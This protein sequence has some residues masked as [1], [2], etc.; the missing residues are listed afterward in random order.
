MIHVRFHVFSWHGRW[1]KA[2]SIVRG[3]SKLLMNE[4]DVIWPLAVR[5][6]R[7]L[8]YFLGF[9]AVQSLVLTPGARITRAYCSP[10]SSRIGALPPASGCAPLIHRRSK[11]ERNK[12]RWQSARHYLMNH[13]GN[14]RA[15]CS[16]RF[17][18]PRI[19]QSGWEAANAIPSAGTEQEGR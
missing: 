11:S 3:Q 19:R 1:Q 15:G 4:F 13:L 2:E 12:G 10:D 17:H 5:L 8:V 7:L 14:G 18:Q 6:C 9:G 16:R